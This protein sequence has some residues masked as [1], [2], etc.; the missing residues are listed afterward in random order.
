MHSSPYPYQ[1]GWGRFPQ[2][3]L[4]CC[5]G[6]GRLLR[7]SIIHMTLRDIFSVRTSVSYAVMPN[8][9]IHPLSIVI[10]EVTHSLTCNR[11]CN[12]TICRDNNINIPITSTKVDVANWLH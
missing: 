1:A 10:Y 9:T 4:H 12:A 5:D 7:C 2:M 11:L 6:S 3:C 8:K